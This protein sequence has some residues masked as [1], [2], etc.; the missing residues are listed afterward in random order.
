[1]RECAAE[2]T[3]DDAVVVPAVDNRPTDPEL[4]TEPG[5]D[6]PRRSGECEDRAPA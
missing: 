6:V 5:R 4:W 1:M 2:A 3:K